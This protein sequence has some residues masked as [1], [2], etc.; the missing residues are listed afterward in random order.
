MQ[1]ELKNLHRS[2]GLT[3]V[4][5]THD[6]GEALSMADRVAV[7]NQGRIVQV[8]SPEDIYERP[9]TRFVADFVGGSNVV[10]PATVAAWCGTA[11]AAS[12]RP[13]KIALV[14]DRDAAADAITVDGK[15]GE[16]LYQGAMR[17]VEIVTA[18]GSL[19][20]AVPARQAGRSSSANRSAPPS[21]DP[22]SISSRKHDHRR[23]EIAPPRDGVLR[24]FSDAPARR[25]FY[26]M[27][28]LVPLLLWLGIVYLG[29]LFALLAESL[30][31][32]R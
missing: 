21:R 28:L 6:Q 10:E 25:G 20:L 29:S 11:K 5:V 15:V 3:F 31:L 23:A 13:E 32:D 2:L 12:L 8:G 9:R 4:F 19:T 26:L 7:F 14:G 17:R 18:N 16:V 1:G 22:R 27:L 24:R 30:L